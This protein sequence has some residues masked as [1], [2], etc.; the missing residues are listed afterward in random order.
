MRRPDSMMCYF[1]D[2]MKVQKRGGSYLYFIVGFIIISLIGVQLYW[3]ATGVHLQ[4]L[5][6]E[7]NLKIDLTKV[8]HD[9]EEDAICFNYYSKAYIKSGEGL[10][11]I[12]QRYDEGK[13]KFVGPPNGYLDTLS[14]YNI[15]EYK[16]DTMFDK[17]YS[18]YFKR[19]ATV[20]ITL[21]FK[22]AVPN[23]HAKMIDTNAYKLP[24]VNMANFRAALNNHQ[25]IDALINTDDLDSV[26]KVTL[27]KNNFDTAYEMGIK[28]ADEN[29]YAFL[30]TGTKPAHLQ[31]GLIKVAMFGDN[32]TAPYELSLYLPDPTGHTIRSMAALMA[33]SVA[34]IILLIISYAYF[35]KTILNQ[36]KLSEMKS[37]FIN[38]ITHEF[39]TPITN[40]NLAVENWRN[41]QNNADFYAGIIEE[42]NK[43][44]Q[45]NVEQM[46]QLSAIEHTKIRTD[47]DKIDLEQLIKETISSF[48]IQIERIK[49]IVEYHLVPGL[50]IYGDR[51][52]IRNLLYNL[53]DNAIKYSKGDLKITISTFEADGKT[54]IE[55]QDNGIGMSAET[56]KYMYERF[57]RG[58][59]SDRH[60]VQGFGIGLSY[61]KYIVDAHNGTI[62]VKSKKNEGTKFTIYFPKAR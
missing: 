57:Y 12:K 7:R 3:M 11:I 13:K 61:V 15:F 4:K 24:N 35:V 47:I 51:L 43:H 20:D 29:T 5:V 38:N 40:I 1:Y 41:A 44:M 22:F 10:Y 49:G 6:A 17:D 36:K 56:M 25:S 37:M 8:I 39:N 9:V 30:K 2:S 31:D 26:I 19:N 32:F 18:L 58:D 59:T 53:V 54:A 27:K 50:W 14:L 23:T 21:K 42:E 34:I 60:D 28:R 55:I 48:N 33:S 52:L 46:L 45:K 62:H 16:G